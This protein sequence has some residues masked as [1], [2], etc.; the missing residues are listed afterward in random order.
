MRRLGLDI[1]TNSIGWCLIEDDVR[2]VAIGSRIFSD[3]RDPKSGASLA[4]DRRAA[5]AMRRRRD[6][7]LRRRSVF[8]ENLIRFGL[9]PAD[10]DEAKLLAERDPYDLRARALH[11]RLEPGEI[12][13]ALFHLNQRRGFQSNRKA[14]RG[15]KDSEDGKIAS[16][17]RELDQAMAEA[18]ADTL[19]QFLV[20]R[21]E[22]RVR[23]NGESQSYDFY[24]QRRH[25]EYE[26]GRIWEE[27]A[28]Y[29]PALLTEEA[30]AALHRIL[31]F[32][33]PLK[34]PDVG[35]CLFAGRGGVP[36]TERR[37]P[38]AHPLFQQRR[39]YEEVNQL[40]ITAPGEAPR[41]LTLE[42]RDELLLELRGKRKVSY[43]A[44]GKRLKLQPGESFN[45]ASEIRTE[46]LG[47]EVYAA[48]AAKK[49]F[50]KAWAHLSS[51][52]QWEIASRLLDE[53]D[54]DALHAFL[55]E[56]CG[57]DEDAARATAK[58]AL[59]DGHGRLGETA[60]RAI[61][62]ELKKDVVTYSQAVERAG[63][64]H[65]DDRTG[66]VLD[67]LPYYGELLSRDI[68]P[69]TFDPADADD[70]E[71][72]WGKITNPTVHIGLRQLEK[73][74]N[75]IIAVHGRPDQIVVELARELKLN[76]KDKDEHNRRIRKDTQAAI[77]RGVKLAQEGIPDT[78]GNR[79][80]LKLWEE[81]NPANPLDRRCP[82]CAEP[83]GMRAL[84][85][86]EADIDHIIPYSRSLDDSGGNKVVAHRHCNRIK[87]N[88]TPYERW[89]HD[90]E[91]WD[92]IAGQV[93]RLHRSKQWRFG[94]DAMARVEK[95]G[96]FLARQLTDT[97]YL[98]R[99]AG[100]YL[101]SLYPA[102][103]DGSVYVIPGRMTAMLR[104]LWGLNSLLPD[105]NY[106]DNAHSNAPKNRLDHRHHAIDAAV[107]AVTT[108]GLLQQIARTAGQAEDKHLDRLFADLPQPWEGFRE[109]LGEALFRVTTSHKP[110]HG[111]KGRPSRDRD[112]TA[113]RLHND[114]AYGFTGA[115][116]AD[117]RTPI[118]VHRVG[119]ASLKPGDLTNPERIPDAALRDALYAATQ[120]L[121][122]KDYDA[123][124]HRFAQTHPQFGG[125]RRVRVREPLNVIPIRD[126]AGRA[127][128]GYKG[129]ANARFDVWRL[130]AGKCVADIVSMFD[131]HAPAGKD[132]RPHP[133]AKKVLSLRQNDMLAIGEGA[134]R[135]FVRVVK[136]STIG[137]IAL[138]EANE[139]GPLKARDAAPN[140][141]DPFKYILS[142]A[143]GLMKLKARQVRIDP[144][145]RIL[146][147]G[148]R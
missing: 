100:K 111:R 4:V 95:D 72:Y 31:F 64:H 122:G 21:A 35:V 114:T 52:R 117:G 131:A 62:A 125:I 140:D 48:L 69:G 96:G 70:V 13:R 144:L 10:V 2:I 126:K 51:E 45:K 137:T 105:H 16:G 134:D 46:M 76:D 58:A 127:Y 59:P 109:Q 86:G 57:L 115:V 60:T 130:P 40:E 90:E 85:S 129:D 108:R 3:G 112:V 28:R 43:A 66:E 39:L 97:Q 25:I 92:K 20:G 55:T 33:R 71:R 63:W 103:E 36:P 88:R 78:G 75:A 104:R 44:L 138:A 133:A 47:D 124:L 32:Q 93:A 120:G 145:G 7:Y 110:D 54:P 99:L 148:P 132:R 67:R 84:F 136:F 26:F 41:K 15:Q 5:R 22:K 14:E 128:K 81:L 9:M 121:T 68:P 27:Q 102:K 73:L 6:R 50:D 49:C 101:R 56:D 61:L 53:E 89:G 65:S 42:Q 80:L 106:V 24:P 18:G 1:G 77:A 83:I 30:R 141:A 11:E 34:T 139:A 87:G 98:S 119:L 147:P 37:L 135:R 118:V 113:G 82:Y 123:A 107:I 23:L 94:P 79:A 146:D 17:A 143:N 12:G 91:R 116:A 142:S 8:L 74:V 38:K 29:H 19:G